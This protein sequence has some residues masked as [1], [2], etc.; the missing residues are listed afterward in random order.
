ML[1]WLCRVVRAV[2]A[3]QLVMLHSPKE[4]KTWPL[5]LSGTS[6]AS[7]TSLPH[8]CFVIVMPSSV[9][10]TFSL[11]FLFRSWIFSFEKKTFTGMQKEIVCSS[12]LPTFFFFLFFRMHNACNF[13]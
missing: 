6:A 10:G 8:R 1:S 2:Q 7:L 5:S 3:R 11:G 13:V 4:R 12:S 9:L